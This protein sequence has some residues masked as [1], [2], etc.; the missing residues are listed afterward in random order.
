[1]RTVKEV[2]KL[3]KAVESKLRKELDSEKYKAY[4]KM[5][6]DT[7]IKQSETDG[8]SRSITSNTVLIPNT[9]TGVRFVE[10]YQAVGTLRLEA[11]SSGN[12][13]DAIAFK[14]TI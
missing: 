13:T 9:R 3:R 6:E 7:Y 4:V 8:K 1:M 5:V 14:V 11:V 2:K 10:M 12:S